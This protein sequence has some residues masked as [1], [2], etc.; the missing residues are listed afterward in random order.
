MTL[1]TRIA[2]MKGG[3][4]Q[5][6]GTPYEVYNRPANTFVASFMGS[7]RMNLL[8]ARMATERHGELRLVAASGGVGAT[9]IQMPPGL[10]PAG[11]QA[12]C[13][14]RR[15]RRAA[16]R[17]GGP[18]ASRRGTWAFAMPSGST[19][20]SGRT[21]RRRHA[22]AARHRRTRLHGPPAAR[23]VAVDRCVRALFDRLSKV[24]FFDAETEQLI[25]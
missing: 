18:C 8:R 24:V 13:G 7:P 10:V 17:S 20:A 2:V 4:L 1:A 14:A 23:R 15:H 22:G 6:L 12:P 9:A 11:L 16:R 21:H 5:Q 19:R 3:V 25:A